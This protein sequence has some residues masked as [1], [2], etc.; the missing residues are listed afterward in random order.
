MSFWSFC[1]LWHYW[2]RQIF[3]LVYLGGLVS[4]VFAH[5]WFRNY[6]SSRSCFVKCSG[7]VSPPQ[8]A[9]VAYLVLYSSLF[10]L[11]TQRR[12][13]LYDPWSMD[14]RSHELWVKRHDRRQC[15]S[16]WAATSRHA[17]ARGHCDRQQLQYCTG[18]SFQTNVFRQTFLQHCSAICLEL[19]A[20]IFS[21]LWLSDII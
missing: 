16:I 21:E 6:L 15:R 17:A 12:E 2:P 5:S 20:N 7:L 14:H 18:N 19:S 11:C 1:C 3:S 4:V 9:S 8:S 10:T 13:K